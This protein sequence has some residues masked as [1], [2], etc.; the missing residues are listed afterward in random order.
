VVGA[1]HWVWGLSKGGYMKWPC[2]KKFPVKKKKK[3]KQDF[4]IKISFVIK[5][6][7]LPTK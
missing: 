2:L 1:L 4:V 3:K 6:V 5:D 7:G